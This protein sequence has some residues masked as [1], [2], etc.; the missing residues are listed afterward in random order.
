MQLTKPVKDVLLF[1]IT[2]H[3][4]ALG[5][6]ELKLFFRDDIKLMFFYYYLFALLGTLAVWLKLF[7]SPKFKDFSRNI[8]FK[9]GVGIVAIVIVNILIFIQLIRLLY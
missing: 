1:S 3:L 7:P 2:M 9:L 4:V 5:T 8:G 6:Y